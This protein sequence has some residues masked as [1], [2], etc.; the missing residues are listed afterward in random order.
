VPERPLQGRQS[1]YCTVQRQQRKA[2]FWEE[3][4]AESEREQESH[5]ELHSSSLLNNKNNSI[6]DMLLTPSFD[7]GS[8]VSAIDTSDGGML[9]KNFSLGAMHVESSASPAASNADGI[10]V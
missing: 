3:P 9:L 6:A 7:P 1:D 5:R 4:I 2:G 8:K 10:C